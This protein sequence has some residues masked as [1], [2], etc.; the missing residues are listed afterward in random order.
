MCSCRS[1]RIL[2]NN[3]NNNNN[4]NDD[5]DDDDGLFKPLV[6]VKLNYRQWCL[7]YKIK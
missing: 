1:R 3:N 4:N 2:L 7:H 6:V 5:D